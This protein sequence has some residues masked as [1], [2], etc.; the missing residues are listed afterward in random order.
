MILCLRILF[1][2]HI[3]MYSSLARYHDLLASWK[4]PTDRDRCDAALTMTVSP[5]PGCR[6]WSAHGAIISFQLKLCAEHQRRRNFLNEH[7][8]GY[9]R[10][11]LPMHGVTRRMDTSSCRVAEN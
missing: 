6:T 1:P 8:C 3:V 11:V 2:S 9:S 5:E 4:A 10:G 7:S